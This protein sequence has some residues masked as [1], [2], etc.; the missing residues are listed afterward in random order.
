MKSLALFYLAAWR[1]PATAQDFAK[2]YAQNL[3]R[4]YSGLKKDTAAQASAPNDGHTTEQVFTT[5]EGPVLITTRGKLVFI[6][7]SFPL[8]LA[9]QLTSRVLDAQGTGEMKMAMA[10]GKDV[11]SLAGEKADPLSGDMVRFMAHC[12][13]MKAAVDA[14]VQAG[15]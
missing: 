12:G 15:K 7:E 13:V 2:L 3:G 6:T 9:R 11:A 1:N 4:K 5:T 14:A 8:E 10:G